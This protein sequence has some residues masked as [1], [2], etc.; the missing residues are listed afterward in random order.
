MAEKKLKDFEVRVTWMMGG[1]YFVKA[2]NADDAVAAAQ[3]IS[4]LPDDQAY[5]ESSIEYNEAEEVA[6]GKA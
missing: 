6:H 4:S 5:L 2:G 3:D 1:T